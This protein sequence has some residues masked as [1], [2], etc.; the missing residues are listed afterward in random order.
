MDPTAALIAGMIAGLAVAMQVGAVSLLL[1]ETAVVAGPRAGVAAGMG[2]ATVD[3]GFAA[4]AAA[5]GGIT[6]PALASH[7]G[8]I[9]AVGALMLAAIALHGLV[10]LAREREPAPAAATAG[11]APRAHYARFVAITAANPLTITSFAAV[12]AA[13]TPDGPVSA[14]AFAAGVGVASAGWH[15]VL[16]VAA[17][18]AGRWITPPIQRGLG[19]SGRLVVLAIAAH[20]ALG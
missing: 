17:G 15:L 14:A 7:E 19:I 9:R 4:I 13:L 1:V 18:H 16:T 12:A 11:G 3:V 2:V 20:L 8:E 10:T 5:A 6:G